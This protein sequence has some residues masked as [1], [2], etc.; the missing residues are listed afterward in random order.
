MARGS[1]RT[2]LLGCTRQRGK[3]GRGSVLGESEWMMTGGPQK[4]SLSRALQRKSSRPVV[5]MDDRKISHSFTQCFLRVWVLPQAPSAP[6]M[7]SD[8]PFF[9]RAA[10][11][12]CNLD[13]AQSTRRSAG[14]S[15]RICVRRC[16]A[17]V[18]RPRRWAI[19]CLL[20]CAQVT[21]ATGRWDGRGFFWLWPWDAPT[22][23]GSMG[24]L[25]AAG[26]RVVAP[27]ARDVVV[28]LGGQAAGYYAGDGS[29]R[30]RA[31]QGWLLDAFGDMGE[32]WKPSQRFA[33]G[34]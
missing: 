14:K 22:R 11:I 34:G 29:V 2:S 21:R 9:S 4:T 12:P 3:T 24:W 18:G 13:G 8:Q 16:S 17:E 32:H 26:A 23:R 7:P 28:C 30:G 10:G 19:W 20:L 27:R 33:M 1:V 15:A 25:A 5:G 6:R 31:R